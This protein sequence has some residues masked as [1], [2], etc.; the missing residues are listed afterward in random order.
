MTG[1]SC[2]FLEHIVL[3]LSRSSFKCDIKCGSKLAD[4]KFLKQCNKFQITEAIYGYQ[5]MR[6]IM[7]SLRYESIELLY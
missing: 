7:M 6:T 1:R 2:I 4:G 3:F 5:I